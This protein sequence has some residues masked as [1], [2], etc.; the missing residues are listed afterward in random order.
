MDPFEGWAIS[1]QQNLEKHGEGFFSAIRS[2][3]DIH[4]VNMH[5]SI[6]KCF[7]GNAHILKK[8]KKKTSKILQKLYRKRFASQ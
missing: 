2:F 5:L 7:G 1:L 4:A 6:F 8:K 3:E